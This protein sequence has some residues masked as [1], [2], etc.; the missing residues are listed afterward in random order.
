MTAPDP[1]ADPADSARE[2]QATPAAGS[3]G[4]PNSATTGQPTSAPG[5]SPS[6][7]PGRAPLTWF[8]TGAN[9]GLGLAIAR[10]TAAAGDRVLATARRPE[11]LEDL[12][13]EFP[14]SVRAAALDVTRAEQIAPAVDAAIAAF[15]GI[16]VL[17]NN[18][19]YGLRGAVESWSMDQLRRLFDTNVFGVVELTRAVLPHMRDAGSGWIVQMSS[20]AGFRVSPGAAA[21]S[22]SKFALEGLSKGLALEVAPHGIVVTL[23]EPGP[24]RTDFSG[25]SH[26]WGEEHPAYTEI[27]AEEFEAYRARSGRQAN[28]PVRAAEILVG[29]AHGPDKPLHLPLG[30]EAFAAARGEFTSRLAAL[31]EIEAYAADTGFPDDV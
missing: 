31:D 15:G 27:L 7:A 9:S 18:A 22:A 24:F 10:T 11:T 23:A 6:D 13:A 16:D 26:D 19:G 1:A 14:G 2:P 20:V 30:P 3:S 29:L 17:V 5:S 25:R 21:Y 12:V 28:D 4:T 8:I